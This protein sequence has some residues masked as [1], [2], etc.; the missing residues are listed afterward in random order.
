MLGVGA[1]ASE[2]HTPGDYFTRM[3]SSAI[4]ERIAEVRALFYPGWYSW[5]EDAVQGLQVLLTVAVLIA[6]MAATVAHGSWFVGRPSA[7]DTEPDEWDAALTRIRE[8]TT[9]DPE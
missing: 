5:A 9:K 3:D 7:A 8:K 6:L 4:G 2:P 1:D